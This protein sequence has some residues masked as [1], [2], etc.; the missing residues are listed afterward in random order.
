MLQEQMASCS[1]EGGISWFFL[2]CSWRLGILL[3]LTHGTQGVSRV[4]SGKSNLHVSCEGPLGLPLQSVQGPRSSS[5]AEA[6]T[7]SFLSSADM[8]LGVPMEFNR[9]VR[10]RFM[11]RHELCIRLELLK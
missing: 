4:A 5:G 1:E 7:S 2:S 9:G 6:R 8:D 3:Q 11:W 10:L